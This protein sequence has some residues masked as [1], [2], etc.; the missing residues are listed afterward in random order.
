[1][2]YT[3]MTTDF[4]ESIKNEDNHREDQVKENIWSKVHI[5]RV[6]TD[7]RGLIWKIEKQALFYENT[8]VEMSKDDD[9]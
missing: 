8:V 3:W 6:D 5:E 9:W 2:Y 1:M 4:F 7:T